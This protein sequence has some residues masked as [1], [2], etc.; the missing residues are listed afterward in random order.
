MHEHLLIV[1]TDEGDGEK[2]V[3]A[4]GVDSEQLKV[5]SDFATHIY[6]KPEK[7]FIKIK[8]NLIQHSKIENWTSFTKEKIMIE[9]TRKAEK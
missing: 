1:N 3:L 7:A 8:G 6:M 5:F 9:L 2:S 4:I